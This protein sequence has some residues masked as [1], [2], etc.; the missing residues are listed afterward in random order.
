M[1]KSIVLRRRSLLGSR[2]NTLVLLLGLFQ[3][4]QINAHEGDEIT[5]PLHAC[6]NEQKVRIVDSNATCRK[7]ETPIHLLPAGADGSIGTNPT[8]VLDVVGDIHAT[9]T[10][11]SGNSITID[12][13]VNSI[14]SSS[15]T[16]DF[17]DEDLETEGI[18]RLGAIQFAPDGSP[19]VLAIFRGGPPKAQRTI[20]RRATSGT[21]CLSNNHP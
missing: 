20:R 19:D 4:M 10:I 8:D 13:T 11:T 3:V 6:V 21:G 18:M 1:D 7:G 2:A 14:T 16:I 17:D 12:G 15:G 9:G 5:K